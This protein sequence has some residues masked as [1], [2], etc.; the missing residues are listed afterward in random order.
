MSQSSFVCTVKWFKVQ[1]MIT[2][3][4]WPIDGTL[5]GTTTPGQSGP[6]SNCNEGV[7]YIPQS[8]R[9][10]ASSSDNLVSYPGHMLWE[11]VIFLCR[12]AVSIFYT[13]ANRAKRIFNS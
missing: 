3:F 12:D 1:Q 9:I 5:T 4:Y 8:S 13:P 2:Q 11:G 7:F 10:G 6:G